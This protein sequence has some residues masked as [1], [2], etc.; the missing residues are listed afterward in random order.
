MTW[1]RT[2]HSCSGI[3]QQARWLHAEQ[4]LFQEKYLHRLGLLA[5]RTGFE[6]VTYRLTVGQSQKYR[7]NKLIRCNHN[8][9]SQPKS[10]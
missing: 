9:G 8:I 7:E 1:R 3:A 5:P 4:A 6:P 10:S 2:K